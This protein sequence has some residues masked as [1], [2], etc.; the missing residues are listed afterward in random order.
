MG[1][2]G[3]K[4]FFSR[5]STTMLLIAGMIQGWVFYLQSIKIIVVMLK[6]IGQFF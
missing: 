4:G 6:N 2:S 3:H 5:G 1:I